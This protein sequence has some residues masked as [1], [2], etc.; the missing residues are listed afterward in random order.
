MRV[1]FS[2][3]KKSIDMKKLATIFAATAIL[4]S[5]TAFAA[6]NTKSST[7]TKVEKSFSRDF[8][9]AANISWEKKGDIFIAHFDINNESI[10]AA[11]NEEGELVAT[12]RKVNASDLPLSISLAIAKKYPGYEVANKGEEITFEKQTNYY[13]NVGNDKEILKLKCTVNGELTVD[14]KTK[15]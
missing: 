12:S 15:I 9:K 8:S 13:I 2:N 6:D 3:T 1:G 4:F 5:A 10:E 14:R 11:Y 7:T